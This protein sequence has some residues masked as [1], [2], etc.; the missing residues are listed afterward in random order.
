MPKKPFVICVANAQD[1]SKYFAM[2]Y[3]CMYTCVHTYMYRVCIYSVCMYIGRYTCMLCM[4]IQ[5]LFST[6]TVYD[7]YTVIASM[8]VLLQI[9]ILLATV[10]P[11]P[12]AR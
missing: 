10:V 2:G 9:I 1:T 7:K 6:L 5:L 4:Y 11:L 3:I 8:F 12:S